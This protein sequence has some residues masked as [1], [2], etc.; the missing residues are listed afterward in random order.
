MKKK[1]LLLAVLG[2]LLYNHGNAQ[3]PGTESPAL[4]PNPEMGTTTPKKRAFFITP[5]YEFTQFDKLELISHTNYYTVWEGENSYKYT[6][7]DIKSYN[8]N[9]GTAYHNSMTGI[10]F[11]YQVMNGLGVS[12]YAGINHYDFRSWI[13]DEN[14]QSF[15]ADYPALTLGLAADYLKKLDEHWTVFSAVSCNFTSSKSVKVQTT[16]GEEIVS[17][18]L[19]S[20]YW[21]LNLAMAY[22]I[23]RFLP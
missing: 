16:N 4:N 8:D 18:S 23:H 2:C 6:A 10:K 3:S 14:T 19:K 1:L 21:E 22:R 11:G 15:D 12:A 9:Y 20:M 13:S 17:S 5:F 7:E